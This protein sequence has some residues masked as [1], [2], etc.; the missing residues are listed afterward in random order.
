LDVQFEILVNES[1]TVGTDSDR[2]GVRLSG[3]EVPRTAGEELLSEAVTP[4]TIQLPP[5]GNPIVLLGDCQTIGGYPKIAHVITVDLPAAAQLSPG[6]TVR[7]A[8]VSLAEA[9]RLLLQR[10]R[11]FAWFR[12]GV[13]LKLR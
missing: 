12:A 5:N 11:D 1:F 2:M 4:G 7:F 3:S 6:G 13:A 9:Q 10:Q 8:E